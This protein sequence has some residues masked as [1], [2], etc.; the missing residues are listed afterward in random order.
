MGLV[1]SLMQVVLGNHPLPNLT[2]VLDEYLS[3][4]KVATFPLRL[5]VLLVLMETCVLANS[6]RS[7][8]AFNILRHTYLFY[9]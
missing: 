9:A 6:R 7:Q 8:K 4:S 2:L 1:M 5:Q 3:T